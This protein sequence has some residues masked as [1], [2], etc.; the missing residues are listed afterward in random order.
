MQSPKTRE[1]HKRILEGKEKTRA[2]DAFDERVALRRE[3]RPDE[4]LANARPAEG[5]GPDLSRGDR[6]IRRGANQE[7]RHAKHRQDD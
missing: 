4:A 3:A 7:S 1:Q 6:S 2:P 5:Q